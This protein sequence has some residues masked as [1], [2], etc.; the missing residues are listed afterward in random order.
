MRGLPT[1]WLSGAGSL[2]PRFGAPRLSVISIP[3]IYQCLCRN[4]AS[5]TL[6][7]Q[8][9][10]SHID[11]LTVYI[12]HDGWLSVGSNNVSQ[13]SLTFHT[14]TFRVLGNSDIS[15]AWKCNIEWKFNTR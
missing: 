9:L 5:M 15:R 4:S 2:W 12:S 13:P 6:A 3:F 10:D 7:F 1:G 14:L 11:K 8:N